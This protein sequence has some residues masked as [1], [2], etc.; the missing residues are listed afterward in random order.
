M[1]YE[2]VYTRTPRNAFVPSPIF[3]GIVAIFAV[4]GVLIWT[5]FGNVGFDAFLFVVSG[6]VVSLC[7]HEYA[8]AVAA[9]FSGDLTVAER[10]YLRLN[11]L[12][13][14]H[15]VLSIV[16]PVIVVILGGIG[17]PGGAV[18]VD[19]RYIN[20]R[21]KDSLISAAGPA[22][23][24]LLALVAALPFLMGLGPDSVFDGHIAFWQALSL[25]AF[26]QITASVLN[27]LPVPGLDGGSI[28][29][30]WLSPAYRRAWD[31]FAP[32]GFLLLFV[33]LW[34]TS[35]GGY[36]YDVVYRI[37][38]HLGLNPLLVS[39]GYDLMRFWT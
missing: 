18:W 34:Q 10:G 31:T 24:V 29:R 21:A 37:A 12:K 4:S 20:S 11:P 27:V 39:D 8:H 32:F 38:D 33:A 22:T 9:Y 2:P 17:L 19:H 15:P 13:Y 14:T 1:T 16:L 30:P 6:W 35:L 28:L 25:V 23:N 26:L 5:G 3:V 7:L 36:F